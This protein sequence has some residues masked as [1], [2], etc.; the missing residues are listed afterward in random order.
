MTTDAMDQ[1]REACGLMNSAL[2]L[3]D[4]ADESLAAIELSQAIQTVSR[5]IVASLRATSSS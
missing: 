2:A 1:L 4:D 3:L 5:R